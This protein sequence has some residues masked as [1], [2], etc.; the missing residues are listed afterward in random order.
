MSKP[1][2]LHLDPAS[3]ENPPLCRITQDSKDPIITTDFYLTN[4]E[5]REWILPTPLTTM[6][7]LQPTQQQQPITHCQKYQ[8]TH[9]NQTKSDYTSGSCILLKPQ[10]W[11]SEAKRSLQ[12]WIWLT[13]FMSYVYVLQT[14]ILKKNLYQMAEG[15]DKELTN[16]NKQLSD[17]AT[18]DDEPVNPKLNTSVEERQ[19]GTI[20]GLALATQAALSYTCAQ[21]NPTVEYRP[22]HT[23]TIKKLTKEQAAEKSTQTDIQKKQK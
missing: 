18:S 14:V 22:S 1:F 13:L 12:H 8:L 17:S 7:E 23:K 11:I 19:Y 15:K 21:E 9:S 10:F 20:P 3:L 16:L 4:M 2:D 5:P 6:K